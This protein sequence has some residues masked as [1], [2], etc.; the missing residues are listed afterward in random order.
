[1][2]S[3]LLRVYSYLYHAGIS[4]FLLGISSLAKMSDSSTFKLDVL[5]WKGADLATYL[6][7][8]SV[9]GLVSVVLAA[10]GMFRYLFPI[11]AAVV[12]WYMVQGFLLQPYSF[13]DVSD[14]Y[15][16]LGLIAGAMLALVGALTVFKKR[17]FRYR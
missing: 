6:F 11:W 15:W 10:T 7:W 16:A 9:A 17:N 3:T 4:I 12:L 14:L 1:M 8:G 13:E 5:P 2:L